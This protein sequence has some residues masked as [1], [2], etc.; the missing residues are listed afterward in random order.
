MEESSD[1]L[2]S[3]VVSRISTFS[4][5]T[6]RISSRSCM[7]YVWVVRLNISTRSAFFGILLSSLLSSP[8][9]GVES[10]LLRDEESLV[11]A[12]LLHADYA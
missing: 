7:I 9:R 8:R 6:L 1:F 4:K 12:R 5:Y 2:S 3:D 11:A 10:S